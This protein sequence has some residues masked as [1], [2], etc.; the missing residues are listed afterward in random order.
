MEDNEAVAGA[1]GHLGRRLRERHT[2][3]R[4]LQERRPKAVRAE[5][6]RLRTE[7]RSPP[8]RSVCNQIV[9]AAIFEV[10]AGRAPPRRCNRT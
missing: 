4:R 9:G 5:V 1:Y 7:R 2:S 8:W 3:P 6:L 10:A